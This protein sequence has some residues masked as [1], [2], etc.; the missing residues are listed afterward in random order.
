MQSSSSPAGIAKMCTHFGRP[1]KFLSSLVRISIS[2]FIVL[3]YLV[4]NNIFVLCFA[5]VSQKEK[6]REPHGGQGSS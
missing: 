1:S 3:L 6:T 2:S 5:I 4:V